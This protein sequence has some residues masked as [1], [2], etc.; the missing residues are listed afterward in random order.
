[1]NSTFEMIV[2]RFFDFWPIMISKISLDLHAGINIVLEFHG[3]A[4]EIL[5]YIFMIQMI[6]T[7]DFWCLINPLI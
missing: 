6:K 5:N 1:M 4:G 3:E 7:R 2:Q